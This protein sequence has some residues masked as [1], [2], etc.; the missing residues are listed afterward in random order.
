VHAAAIPVSG[1][2]AWQAL[3]EHAQLE[4]GQKILIPAAAGGVGSIAVQ[5]AK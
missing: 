1:L 4:A 3:F 2:A 5:L